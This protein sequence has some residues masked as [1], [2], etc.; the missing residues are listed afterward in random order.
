MPLRHKYDCCQI[1]STLAKLPWLALPDISGLSPRYFDRPCWLWGFKLLLVRVCCVKHNIPPSTNSAASGIQHP[2]SWLRSNVAW[3]MWNQSCYFRKACHR[4]SSYPQPIPWIQ[5]DLL[6]R[7]SK[8]LGVWRVISAMK[9]SVHERLL[10]RE[11]GENT[12]VSS[13]RGLYGDRA[14]VNELDI[15]CEL[16]GHS[17]CVNALR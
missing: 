4:M 11:F 5:F 14:W 13:I 3:M 6:I 15:V 10:R 8:D 9:P 1:P 7:L 17:G 12:R 16:G 2:L